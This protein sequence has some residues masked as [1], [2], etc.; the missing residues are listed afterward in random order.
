MQIWTSG[1]SGIG[2]QPTDRDQISHK[3]TDQSSHQ[4]ALNQ[5]VPLSDHAILSQVADNVSSLDFSKSTVSSVSTDGHNQKDGVQEVLAGDVLQFE[6]VK[7][8][9]PLSAGKEVQSGS[10]DTPMADTHA[11]IDGAVP[12]AHAGSTVSLQHIEKFPPPPNS[13]RMPVSPQ[14]SLVPFQV[15]SAIPKPD[16]IVDTNKNHSDGQLSQG[17]NAAEITKIPSVAP[18]T[19]P[20]MDILESETV[21]D[22]LMELLPSIDGKRRRRGFFR[23]LLDNAIQ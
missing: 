23:R 17:L 14:Q 11:H 2:T 21:A 12:S 3:Q 9:P 8:A 20:T 10:S 5:A 13:P 6:Y 16:E 22:L 19:T 7:N 4:D 15:D 18:T 1:H